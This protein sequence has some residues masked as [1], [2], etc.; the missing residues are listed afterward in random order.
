[1]GEGSGGE[2]R[3]R[4]RC[5]EKQERSSDGQENEWKSAAAWLGGIGEISRISQSSKMG[6]ASRSQCE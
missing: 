3:G 4:I 2:W 5:E 6:E 1:M